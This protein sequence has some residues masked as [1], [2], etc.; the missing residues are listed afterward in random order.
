MHGGGW[1]L[2]RHVSEDSHLT[3][4]PG[5]TWARRSPARIADACLGAL[6]ANMARR[7]GRPSPLADDYT[8]RHFGR[9]LTPMIVMASSGISKLLKPQQI[10]TT[11][12]TFRGIFRYARSG[13]DAGNPAVRVARI[14][15]G[16]EALLLAGVPDVPE[17]ALDPF[18]DYVSEQIAAEPAPALNE[19]GL[20][21]R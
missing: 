20:T 4:R 13:Q 10:L 9:A 2:L 19:E 16:M 3:R 11:I 6:T 1:A 12:V 17:R 7:A 15:A 18:L 5:R 21:R 8:E 14:R